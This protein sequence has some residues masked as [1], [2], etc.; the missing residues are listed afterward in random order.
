MLFKYSVF[1]SIFIILYTYLYEVDIYAVKYDMNNF[2][3]VSSI[4]KYVQNL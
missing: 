4:L 3:F 2:T 1:K